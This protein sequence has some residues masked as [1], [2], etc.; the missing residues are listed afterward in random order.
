MKLFNL[1]IN[2]E[3]QLYGRRYVVTHINAPKVYVIAAGNAAV[4]EEYDFL[5]LI[6]NPT[7]EPSALIQKRVS[8][9]SEESKALRR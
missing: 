8:Q 1:K 6:T 5:S 3:F 9:K 2:D 4:E 7:F